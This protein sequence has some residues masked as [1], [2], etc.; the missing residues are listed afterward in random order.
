MQWPE[1][2][3]T[4]T[5]SMIKDAVENGAAVNLGTRSVLS[6]RELSPLMLAVIYCHNTNTVECL[7]QL[8]ANVDTKTCDGMSV[9]HL[10]AEDDCSNPN[11]ID[12]LVRNGAD[13]NARNNDGDTPLMV[14][15][16]RNNPDQVK[17]LALAGANVNE[18]VKHNLSLLVYTAMGVN[19]N[20]AVVDQ[21]IAHGANISEPEKN[22]AT[23]LVNL[24]LAGTNPDA[25]QRLVELGAPVNQPD[26][27]GETPLSIA[28]IYNEEIEIVDKLIQCGADTKFKTPDGL[29]LLH[30]AILNSPEMVDYIVQLG[31]D[32]NQRLDNGITLMMFAAVNC[33]NPEIIDR[34]VYHGARV[35]E[36]SEKGLSPLA[37][38]TA[39]NQTNPEI[40]T[41]LAL[42]SNKEVVGDLA[43]S[44]LEAEDY[45][46]AIKWAE[47]GVA[48]GHGRSALI[49]GICNFWGKGVTENYIEGYAWFLVGL[50]IDPDLED[51]DLLSS[52]K[53]AMNSQQ[54]AAGQK[55][56]NEIQTLIERQGK[57]D[58][59]SPGTNPANAGVDPSGYGSGLLIRG[60]YVLTCW[61]VV[62]SSKTVTVSAGGQD[63]VMKVVRKDPDNDVAVLHSD[64]LDGGVSL[65]TGSSIGLGEKVFTLGYP[66]PELQGTGVKFTTGSVSGLMGPGDTPRYYQISAPLQSGNSGGPLFD[67]QGN[68]VGM[69]AAKLDSM[70]TLMAT[71]DLPQNVN[72]AIKMDYILPL[73]K[74]VEGIKI[75]PTQQKNV[76]LLEL[77][78]ELKQSAVMIK[79]Y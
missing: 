31:F 72:Y 19:C 42:L 69:V 3:E 7:I 14:A 43:S 52:L 25:I 37:L 17:H 78:D 48:L 5:P 30:L 27:N 55:R 57:L 68:L 75:V 2:W 36:L 40:I 54:I 38:A 26:K 8:G 23:P 47:R 11:T 73:L 44:Y 67:E 49:L 60:G 6:N 58:D 29:N 45:K 28:V 9:L 13:I 56:A 20:L 74:T 32:V 39:G 16:F 21:L 24:V 61:H 79:V 35:N 65:S 10:V 46:N 34:L 1:W 41:K 64:D 62:D 77:I 33:E 15:C 66:H 76:G 50:S 51:S 63:H 12:V 70:A 71:G 59:L 4:A 22:G 18:T 53:G